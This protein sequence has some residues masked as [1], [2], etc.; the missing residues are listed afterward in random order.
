MVPFPTSALSAISSTVTLS[1]PRAE[2]RSI[3]LSTIRARSAS[4]LRCRLDS[5]V[6]VTMD[7]YDHGHLC[8]IWVSSK[9]ENQRAVAYWPARIVR[10]EDDRLIW[11]AVGLAERGLESSKTRSL[12]LLKPTM[13]VSIRNCL[14]PRR[15]GRCY[16]RD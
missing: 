7:I 14:T 5:L 2:Q 10:A 15:R 6:M 3:A 16:A 12:I 4:F 9:T 13:A 11:L 8:W 1:I